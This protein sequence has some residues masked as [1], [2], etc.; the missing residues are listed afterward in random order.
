MT[1]H[2]TAGLQRWLQPAEADPEAAARLFLFPYAG[3]NAARMQRDW[4]DLFPADIAV[5]SLQ[6]PGRLD[7]R[8]ERP[9]TKMAPLVHAMCE[10]IAA[11]VDDRPYAFFGHS[12]GALLA[13]RVAVAMEQETGTGPAL[14]ASAGWSPEGFAMPTRE[15][16]DLPQDE[17]VKWIIGLGSVPP[18]LYQ[19]EELLALTLP[20]TRADLT[21]CLDYTDDGAHVGCPVVTYSGKSDPLVVSDAMQAWAARS[22]AY[23]GNCEFPGGHFFIYDAAL[24][25]ASDLTRHLRRSVVAAA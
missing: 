13:Y 2:A 15:Q 10:A 19:D 20:A 8:A 25:I 4:Q 1:D 17:L 9:F 7:R 6:L 22:P 5:Q 11:E 23:L 3:G 12:M 16:I 24:A 14:I 21:A 18:A